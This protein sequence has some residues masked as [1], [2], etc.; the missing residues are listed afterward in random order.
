MRLL[1][2]FEIPREKTCR[3]KYRHCLMS[4]GLRIGKK[5]DRSLSVDELCTEICIKKIMIGKVLT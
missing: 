1:Y 5:T 2:S 4:K 3:G